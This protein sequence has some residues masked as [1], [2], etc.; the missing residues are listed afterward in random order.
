MKKLTSKQK[1][2]IRK[3]AQ[4]KKALFQIGTK[5]LHDNNIR[6][7]NEYF[8]GNEILKIKV[9]REDIY[10]KSITKEIANEIKIK[11]NCEIAGIIGTTIICYKENKDRLKRLEL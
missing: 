2:K 1:A 6:A 8:N 3:I 7:I 4:N 11:I 9:N 10:D 5:E